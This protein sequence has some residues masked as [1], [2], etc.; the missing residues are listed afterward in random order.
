MKILFFYVLLM[1]IFSCE[2]SEY[3]SDPV[4]DKPTISLRLELL[5]Q[6]LDIIRETPEGPERMIYLQISTTHSEFPKKLTLHYDIAGKAYERELIDAPEQLTTAM[7][8]AWIPASATSFSYTL[9]AD[10]RPSLLTGTAAV[11]KAQEEVVIPMSAA[12]T[13][14]QLTNLVLRGTNYYPRYNSWGNMWKQQTA[15]QFEAEFAEMQALH[16]NTIR[17]FYIGQV[18][19]THFEGG[20]AKP[21]TIQKANQLFETADRHHMKVL[22]CM[23]GRDFDDTN[24]S[25]WK[26]YIRTNVEPF[27]YDGRVLLWDLINEPGGNEGPASTAELSNWMKEMYA[28]ITHMD[29]NHLHTVGLTWQFDQLHGLGIKPEVEQYHDYSGA[30]GVSGDPDERSILNDLL[31]YHQLVEGR[32]LIIGEFG[33]SSNNTDRIPSSE[34][35]QLNRYEWIVEGVE[36]AIQQ[37]VNVIGIFN[38][39]AFHFPNVGDPF[40]Q[41]FGVIN[42]DGSLKPAGTF[43]KET[44]ARWKQNHPAPWD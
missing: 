29:I 27:I 37:D 22:M 33:I 9:S 11:T 34:A 12:T 35:Y 42:E 24:L 3:T 5:P 32:P 26:R 43:L 36:A 31:R 6:S 30:V 1:A 23:G 10:G 25:D 20:L 16:I 2:S 44:Y 14:A 8:T 38:W 41:A 39:C 7:N 13:K 40:E 21:E 18:P 19:E 15:E 4:P 17:T 28:F